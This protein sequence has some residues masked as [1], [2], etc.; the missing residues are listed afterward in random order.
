MSMTLYNLRTA[1][2]DYRITKFTP[3]LNVESSYL[4]SNTFDE[5][6][7]PQLL[8][9]CPAGVRP[10][11]RH[12]QMLPE[13]LSRN[14][15]DSELFWDFERGLCVNSDGMMCE[16][17]EGLDEVPET[18]PD[19]IERDN[20]LAHVPASANLS[21]SDEPATSAVSLSAKWRRI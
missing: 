19:D 2:D 4:I 16:P 9:E 8:C 10:W 7:Q 1:L 5:S 14:M 21:Q 20:A 12:R 3:D 17:I 11:C 6:G 18:M 15:L 13:L